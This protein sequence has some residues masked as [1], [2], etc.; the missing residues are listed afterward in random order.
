MDKEWLISE[1]LLLPMTAIDYHIGQQLGKMFPK[2]VFI[3]GDVGGFNVEAY[4]GAGLCTLTRKTFLFNQA[5][6]YWRE[7]E[8]EMMHPHMQMMRM[9]SGF[10]MPGMPGMPS[11]T[12]SAENN[13]QADG[14]STADMVRKA[15]LDVEWQGH[16]LEALLIAIEGGGMY[17]NHFWLLAD[18]QEI[19]RD[20][21][22]AVCKWNMEIRSE[23]LVFDNGFWHKDERIFQ[24]IKNATFD[25]LILPGNLKEEIRDD[26]VQFFGARDLYEEH[27]IPWK[28]GILFV[29]PPGNGKTHTVKALLNSLEYP[30]LYV[31]SFR[32]PHTQGADEVNIRQVFER[33]R[34][35]T[36][37][38]LVLEDLDSLVTPQNRSFFLNEL[39]GFAA[40]IGIVTLA[41]SNHPERLDPAILERP[42]RFDRKYP[43]DL[44]AQTER[45]AYIML[46][47]ESLKPALRLTEKEMENISEATND[48]SY[49]YLKELFVSSKMR[50]IAKPQQG[51]MGQ[52][53]QE[54]VSKLRE[55]MSSPFALAAEEMMESEGMGPMGPMGPVEGP[56]MARVMMGGMR[57]VRAMTRR[58]Q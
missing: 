1:M 20:F 13:E 31:K 28:R 10:G 6:T 55:Q 26:L 52:V 46:W 17:K 11:P 44:P 27:D 36:P 57:G 39:D 51:T 16:A 8:P 7:P 30:C 4:A 29:G 19:A 3:E 42:S 54:Q 33:A 14:S 24:D 45:K 34:R 43:F 49:A 41:T 5:S 38:V 56:G 23:V 40:N 48:F 18:T 53:M 9:R 50:W 32:S 37:C 12:T 35:S 22:A 2:K 25:N 47:N 21:F 58:G 15:W